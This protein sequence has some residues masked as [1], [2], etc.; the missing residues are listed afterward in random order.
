MAGPGDHPNVYCV[1][2]TEE[3]SELEKAREEWEAVESA[4]PGKTG[5]VTCLWDGSPVC[6]TGHLSVGSEGSFTSCPVCLVCIYR[7]VSFSGQ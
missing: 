6:G 7:F 5:R 4:Q 1:P 2:P 3:S